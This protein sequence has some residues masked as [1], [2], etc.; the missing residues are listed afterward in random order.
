M[1]EPVTPRG[2]FDGHALPFAAGACRLEDATPAR[3]I[4]VMPFR[5]CAGRAAAALGTPLPGPGRSAAAGAGRILWTGRAAWLL[6]GSAAPDGLARHAA[7]VDVSGGLAGL[8]ISG[9]TARAV[10]ERLCPLDL[11]PAAFPDGATARSVVAHLSGQISRCGA[12]Y[13]ILVARP[14]ATA[15]LEELRIAMRS[16]AARPG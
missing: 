13:E 14:L 4:M 5:G 11:D 10:L 1:A 16:L 12:G 6:M 15:L 7:V 9:D 3:A 8:G 2:P